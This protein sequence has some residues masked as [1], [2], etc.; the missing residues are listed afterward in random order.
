M[1]QEQIVKTLEILNYHDD[2]L[3]ISNELKNRIPKKQHELINDLIIEIENI[4]DLLADL[5]NEFY[6]E[7]LKK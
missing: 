5:E 2:L 4:V 6:Y 3:N 1:E 7:Y